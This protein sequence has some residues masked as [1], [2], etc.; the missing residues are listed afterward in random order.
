MQDYAN[1]IAQM[2]VGYQ[3]DF[4]DLPRLTAVGKGRLEVDLNQ[5]ATHLN[6]EAVAPFQITEAVRGWYVDALAR[7]HLS[8]D[9][10]KS[11]EIDCAFEITQSESDGRIRRHVQLDCSVKLEAENGTWTGRKRRNEEGKRQGGG[12]WMLQEA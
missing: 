1:Q 11:I 12:P 5:D 3:I 7:D 8:R 2:F 10:V 6:G 4:V 9:F